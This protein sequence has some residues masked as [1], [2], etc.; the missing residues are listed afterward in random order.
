MFVFPGRAAR[1]A[2]HVGGYYGILGFAGAAVT[3]E[4]LFFARFDLCS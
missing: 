2:Q 4:A 3:G 1:L